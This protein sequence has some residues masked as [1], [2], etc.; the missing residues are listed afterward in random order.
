MASGSSPTNPL[1]SPQEMHIW[2]QNVGANIAHY[3]RLVVTAMAEDV[4]LLLTQNP[5]CDLERKHR[6]GD[7]HLI[8]PFASVAEVKTLVM[9]RHDQQF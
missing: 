4:C 8:C 5:L 7:Y 3:Q 1:A 9:V 6:L 2:E